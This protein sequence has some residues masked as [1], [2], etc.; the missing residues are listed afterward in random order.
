MKLPLFFQRTGPINTG[1]REKNK[2]RLPIGWLLTIAL[3]TPVFALQLP[4]A[5]PQNLPDMPSVRGTVQAV[6]G[7]NVTVQTDEGKTYTIHISDNTHI[8]KNRQPLK[9]SDIH[10]GDMLIG[11]G[12]LDARNNL[13]RAI[14]VADVDAATVEKM[15]ADLGKTWIAGKVL[16]IDETKITVERVDHRTQ[17]IEADETTSFRKDGQ[18]ITLLDIHVGDPVRGKGAIKNGV[19]VPTQLTVIDPTRR[20]TAGPPVSQNP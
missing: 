14:F 9:A 3:T 15:K 20:R 11:A 13:L 6:H 16:K 10:T 1:A 5:G 8:Y 12:S 2:I 4:D 7:D 18:S 19:F 17:V